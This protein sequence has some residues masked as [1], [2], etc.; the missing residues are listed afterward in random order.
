MLPQRNDRARA[1]ADHACALRLF[2]PPPPPQYITYKARTTAVPWDPSFG[3]IDD[4]KRTALLS[5]IAS[6][7][8]LSVEQL[9]YTPAEKK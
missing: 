6:K 2:P 1:R 3:D 9:G 8:G 4:S 5:E 7:T